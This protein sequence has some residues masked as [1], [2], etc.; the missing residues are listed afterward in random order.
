MT[1]TPRSRIFS[2][3]ERRF[4]HADMSVVQMPVANGYP[5]QNGGASFFNGLG[6]QV[7][8]W[9]SHGDKVRGL[10]VLLCFFMFFPTPS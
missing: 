7:K 8:V 5:T 6:P 9:M 2:K 3:T 10:S 1:A 4:G